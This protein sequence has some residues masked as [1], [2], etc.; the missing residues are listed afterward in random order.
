MS[1]KTHPSIVDTARLNIA[2]G[3]GEDIVTIHGEKTQ[4]QRLHLPISWRMYERGSTI[5]QSDSVLRYWAGKR[6]ETK[7]ID[8]AYA[9]A[10]KVVT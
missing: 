7:T 10:S 5:I 4:P 6:T 1:A 8:R 9:L 3:N 2:W